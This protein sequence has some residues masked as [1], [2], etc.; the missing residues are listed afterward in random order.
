MLRILVADLGLN[1]VDLTD[2]DALDFSKA[3]LLSF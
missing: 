2:N 3:G 1:G